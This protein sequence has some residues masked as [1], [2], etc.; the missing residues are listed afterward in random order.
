MITHVEGEIEDGTIADLAVGTNSGL[1]RSGSVIRS[2]SMEAYNR[3]L[4]I[5]EELNKD[6]LFLGIKSFQN[7]KI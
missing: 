6:A 7:Y 2:D 1:I 3:L 4:K 5:E